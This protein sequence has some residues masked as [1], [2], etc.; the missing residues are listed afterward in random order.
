MTLIEGIIILRHLYYQ[1][2]LL[3]LIYASVRVRRHIFMQHVLRFVSIPSVFSTGITFSILD[4]F[5][6]KFV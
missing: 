4:P 6:P 2:G 3:Q 5:M 1:Q